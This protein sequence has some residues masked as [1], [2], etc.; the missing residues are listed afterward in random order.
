MC[1]RWIRRFLGAGALLATVVPAAH[2]QL[3]GLTATGYTGLAVPFGQF[4]E[5]TAPGASAGVQIA[6]PLRQPLAIVLDA[7]LDVPQSGAPGLPDLRLWRYQAG[8][9]ADLLGNSAES[10]AVRGQLGAG[11]TTFRSGGFYPRAAGSVSDH[12]EKTYFTG[13]GGLA[14]VFGARSPIHGYL[15]AK[16]NWTPVDGDDLASLRSAAL[17]PAPDPLENVVSVPVT[18]GLRVR[19]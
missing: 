15:G 18:L 4:A 17:G 9:E 16:V 3:S 7:G 19:V 13:S 6:Y 12:F 14:L 8:V 10:W 5:Y 1:T 11:G 2:A